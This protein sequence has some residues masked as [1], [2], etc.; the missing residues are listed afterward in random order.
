MPSRFR[1]AVPLR[2]VDVDAEGIVNN[3]IYLS[4]MEQARYDYF[5]ALGLLAGGKVPFVLAEV[6]VRFVRPGRFGMRTEVEVATTRL[7]NS[8]FAMDYSVLGDDQ[9]LATGSAALVFVDGELRPCPM[10]D[11]FRQAVASREGIALRSAT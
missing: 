2:W 10:P 3:A 8:S 7:G 6:N 1:V 4:M 5:A 9:V 11:A